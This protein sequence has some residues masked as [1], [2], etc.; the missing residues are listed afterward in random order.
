VSLNR[1][2]LIARLTKDPELRDA[3]GTPVV[4]LRVAYNTRKKVDGEWAEVG[5]FI[6]V[7]AFG[8]TAENVAQY[9][10]KGREIAID[11]RLEIRQYEHEGQK[12]ESAEIIADSITFIGGKD[13]AGS[14]DSVSPESG[15]DEAFPF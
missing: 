13:S 12:R 7:T 8:R 2:V 11:G 9:V 5:N 15:A 6:N 3:G 1:S 10:T 4:N 14:A